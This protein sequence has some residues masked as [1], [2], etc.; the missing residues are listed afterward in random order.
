MSELKLFE[1]LTLLFDEE[2]MDLS[3]KMLSKIGNGYLRYWENKKGIYLHRAI[4]S[5]KLNRKLLSGECCDHING[6]RLDNRRVN[7]RVATFQQN[8]INRTKTQNCSSQYVGICWCNQR[9]KWRAYI[10]FNRKGIHIGYF[11]DEYEAALTRNRIAKEL[12]G[13]YAKPLI[14]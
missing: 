9:N 8:N 13:E 10:K 1:G 7:L 11:D 12:F 5:R 6:N 4:L 2:D 3:Q 14:R